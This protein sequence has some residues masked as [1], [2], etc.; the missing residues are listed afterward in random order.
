MKKIL[1]LLCFTIYFS[2]NA[3][4]QIGG[5]VVDSHFTSSG[6]W[7]VEVTISYTDPELGVFARDTTDQEGFFYFDFVTNV[8]DGISPKEY[9]V[10]QNYPNPFNPGTTIEFFSPKEENFSLEIFDAI[11]RKL[12]DKSFSGKG[13]HKFYISNLGSAGVY[14]YRI[15]GHEFLETKKMIQLDGNYGSRVLIDHNRSDNISFHKNIVMNDSLKFDF[16]S[17]N[18]TTYGEKGVYIPKS[19]TLPINVN[20]IEIELTQIPRETAYNIFGKVYLS[21]ASFAPSGTMVEIY[22]DQQFLNSVFTNS[23]GIFSHTHI[24]EQYINPKGSGSG[25]PP[26]TTIFVEISRENVNSAVFQ[27]SGLNES[28]N[29]GNLYVSQIAILKTGTLSSILITDQVNTPVENATLLIEGFG[30]DQ[31]TFL[32]NANGI[33]EGNFTFW[34][35]EFDDDDS[36]AVPEQAILAAIK[37]GFIPNEILVDPFVK[38]ISGRTIA[39]ERVESTTNYQFIVKNL[40]LDETQKNI[41]LNIRTS[42]GVVHE[43]HGSDID[44]NIELDDHLSKQVKI[45]MADYVYLDYQKAG[46]LTKANGDVIDFS[47]RTTQSEFDTLTTDLFTLQNSGIVKNYLIPK[48][49]AQGDSI[50]NLEGDA[51]EDIIAGMPGL[52]NRVLGYKPTAASNNFV[53]LF[54]FKQFHNDTTKNVSDSLLNVVQNLINDYWDIPEGNSYTLKIV[55]NLSLDVD[56]QNA[57]SRGSD[58]IEFWIDENNSSSVDFSFNLGSSRLLNSKLILNQNE[59]NEKTASLIAQVSTASHAPENVSIENY[60]FDSNSGNHTPFYEFVKQLSEKI[61][62]LIY[63]ANK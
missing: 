17:L 40:E 38:N 37:T 53:E 51:A 5:K 62:G 12:I 29:F 34:G 48:K 27:A 46:A 55:E 9:F 6:V 50:I 14:F 15:S 58:Y 52:S 33:A 54:L 41:S 32:S 25:E 47:H 11:G 61:S 56:Y 42:D 7:D 44:V 60:F 3:Q 23:N 39:I 43:L 28:I 18:T 21:P 13:G 16:V 4:T 35:Y 59:S 45:W 31:Q 63:R 19:I 22:G 36:E 26:F 2:L 30:I 49:I 8:D 57:V 10:S 20:I 1:S 24:R